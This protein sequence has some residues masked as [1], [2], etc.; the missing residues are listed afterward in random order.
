MPTT[1][2]I[3]SSVP[4][5]SVTAASPPTA[6]SADPGRPVRMSASTARPPAAWAIHA[7]PTPERMAP[8]ASKAGIESTS[9][10]AAW[11]AVALV[12]SAYAG[13]VVAKATSP[14]S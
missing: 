11:I 2:T 8:A 4:N 13:A 1:S 7:A 14:G 5:A 9:P 6:S 12:L 3:T 10:S